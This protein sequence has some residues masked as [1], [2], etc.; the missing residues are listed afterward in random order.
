[1]KAWYARFSRDSQLEL[2]RRYARA[3]LKLQQQPNPCPGRSPMKWF[4]IFCLF[5]ALSTPLPAN[6]TAPA[7]ESASGLFVCWSFSSFSGYE[8]TWGVEDL[9]FFN[10]TGFDPDQW[11]R[12]AKAADM[13]YIL[14]LT[15]HHDGFCLWDT[16]STDRKVTN[17]PLGVDVLAAVKKACDRHGL[18]LALYFSEGEFGWQ[19]G[20]QHVDAGGVGYWRN[21]ANPE[22]KKA[23]LKELLTRYGPIEFLWMDYAIGD[24]GLSHADTTAFVKAIQP[25]CLIGYNHGDRGGSDLHIRERGQPGPVPEVYRSAEFTYPILEGQQRQRQR[26]AQWFFSLPENDALAATAEKIYLD[27]MAAKHFGNYFSLDVG[28]DRSGTLRALDV[29]RLQQVGNWLRG[30]GSPPAL[31]VTWTGKA[32]ASSTWQ[33]DPVYGADQ[34]FD[35]APGTRWGAEDG[36]RDGWIQLD[37]E[38]A[39]IIRGLFIREGTWDRVRAWYL[40]LGL[41]DTWTTVAQGTTIGAEYEVEM[42]PAT[43]DRIRLVIVRADGVPTIHEIQIQS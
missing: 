19:E 21:G 34:A 20:A 5:M 39:T 8:W 9:S 42:A 2:G 23:Q 28:P 37:L 31:P 43:A 16:A 15:K 14:F 11:C 40:E 41:G 33:D 32:S 36:A 13:D 35:G 22:L 12:A 7:P 29:E 25:E 6:E 30:K 26:G 18:K 38:K 10:P 27:V 3:V 17:S 1:M 4:S 24:G